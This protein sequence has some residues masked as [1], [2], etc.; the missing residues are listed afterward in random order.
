[1][2]IFIMYVD[3]GDGIYPELTGYVMIDNFI[4]LI[5]KYIV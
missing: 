4:I 2:N 5:G 3:H 1:M